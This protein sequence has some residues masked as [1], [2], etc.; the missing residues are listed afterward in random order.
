MA[1]QSFQVALLCACVALTVWC[2]WLGWQHDG[3]PWFWASLAATVSTLGW[4]LNVSRAQRVGAVAALAGFLSGIIQGADQNLPL[5]VWEWQHWSFL[6]SAMWAVGASITLA[7]SRYAIETLCA[8][9]ISTI[10]I[11]HYVN[12]LGE[13]RLLIECVF[14]VMLLPSI[15][16]IGGRLAR[17]FGGYWNRGRYSASDADLP[18]PVATQEADVR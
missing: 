3:W 13:N 15:G 10:Y 8:A 7:R 1:K 9:I 18:E 5:I 6:A 16:G 17:I 4:G 14:G 12:Y 11:S 2:F